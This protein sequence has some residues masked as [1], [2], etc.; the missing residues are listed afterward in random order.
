MATETK[1]TIEKNELIARLS[2]VRDELNVIAEQKRIMA[3]ADAEV[4][5]LQ[6]SLN[7]K[8]EKH[9]SEIKWTQH[10]KAILESKKNTAENEGYE[11]SKERDKIEKSKPKDYAKLKKGLIIASVIVGIYCLGFMILILNI[12]SD[13][14]ELPAGVLPG[15]IIAFSGLASIL[16]IIAVKNRK[17]RG[18]L[19]RLEA[20]E[21]INSE[22]ENNKKLID[23]TKSA[24]TVTS[25]ELKDLAKNEPNDEELQAFIKK[26]DEEINPE[27]LAKIAEAE[28]I[29]AEAAN[30]ILEKEDLR[31]AGTLVYYL[32]TGRADNLKEALLMMV[33]QNRNE[34]LIDAISAAA[35]KVTYAVNRMS[36]SMDSFGKQINSA[37]RETARKFDESYSDMQYA[38]ESMTNRMSEQL[39]SLNSTIE[40]QGRA[41][42]DA[43]RRNADLLS[44][45]NQN[46]D[47][48]VNKMT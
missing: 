36:G 3:D 46:S 6:D 1:E 35:Y 41:I 45:A 15:V 10:K 18:N 24:I 20:L 30:G 8:R 17:K 7:E 40:S 29:V 43:E 33:D 13:G 32:K 16:P 27:C 38:M 19:L 12:A 39:S 28:K 37:Y 5:R 11:L 42:A 4:K 48:L 23:E 31:N 21:K 9:A 26:V 47:R 22:I 25:L 2:T 44:H 14:E 34:D